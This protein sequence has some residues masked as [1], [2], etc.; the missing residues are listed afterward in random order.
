MKKISRTSFS[1]LE[2]YLFFSH[3]RDA[4]ETSKQESHTRKE[5]QEPQ[6]FRESFFAF[7]LDQVD[8]FS[9]NEWFEYSYASR[10]NG[11]SKHPK[12]ELLVGSIVPHGADEMYIRILWFHESSV[13]IKR[14]DITTGNVVVILW[15]DWKLMRE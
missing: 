3:A 5:N 15:I 2:F 9:E 11:K 14:E 12:K 10:D 4:I 1:Y 7:E 13:V 8:D 6:N